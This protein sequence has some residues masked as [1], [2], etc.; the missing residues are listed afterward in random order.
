MKCGLVIDK[1][2]PILGATPDARVIDPMCIHPFGIAEV[3]C[4]I[5]KFQVTP[6]DASSDPNFFM[7]KR[8]DDQ[9]YLKES[10]PYYAQVQGQLGITGVEWCDFI[11]YTKVGVYVQRIKRNCQFWEQL[12]DKLH[13]Y[14]FNHFIKFASSSSGIDTNIN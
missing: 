2:Y 5:T 10:H 1:G 14:Y 8:G 6:L 3:K 13:G 11:V 12:K 7:E 9:C 4:P